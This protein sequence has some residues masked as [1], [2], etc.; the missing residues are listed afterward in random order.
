MC[1]RIFVLFCVLLVASTQYGCFGIIEM[2][3]AVCEY[4]TPDINIHKNP[5]GIKKTPPWSTKTEFLKEWGKPDLVTSNSAHGETWTY[6]KNLPCGILP[7]FFICA[8]LFL[9]VCDGYDRIEFKGEG[10]RRLETRVLKI[11]GMMIWTANELDGGGVKFSYEACEHPI[12]KPL[13]QKIVADRTVYLSVQPD[14]AEY[15]KLNDLIKDY[16]SAKLVDEGVFKAVAQS[17]D[18]ADYSICITNY[19]IELKGAEKPNSVKMTV[20]VNSLKPQQLIGDYELH[21]KST[22]SDWTEIV[23][24]VVSLIVEN[25]KGE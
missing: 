20:K 6:K 18:S 23:Q 12:P 9:P 19:Q 11:N 15:S 13:Y 5:S 4:E 24:T 10:A 14:E 3:P 25:L 1:R 22:S 7:C 17:P 2:H 8:P 16:L 21:E